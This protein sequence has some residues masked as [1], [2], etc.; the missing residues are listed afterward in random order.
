MMMVWTVGMAS[1]T[2]RGCGGACT[3][4]GGVPR[5]TPWQPVQ[6]AR[7]QDSRLQASSPAHL[8][9]RSVAGPQY[10][11][12]HAACRGGCS[13]ALPR[14][15]THFRTTWSSGSLRSWRRPSQWAARTSRCM[16]CA[17]DVYG[18][19][20]LTQ[21]QLVTLAASFPCADNR[22]SYRGRTAPDG[23]AGMAAA[24]GEGARGV[25]ASLLAESC[26]MSLYH[27]QSL[28]KDLGVE[29]HRLPAAFPTFCFTERST[30][31]YLSSKPWA[32]RHIN[33]QGLTATASH[34]ILKCP[35]GPAQGAQQAADHAAGGAARGRAAQA[36][37]GRAHPRRRASAAAAGRA[38]GGALAHRARRPIR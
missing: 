11:T 35:S 19:C 31:R 34:Q 25:R 2:G 8:S 3:G 38:W 17:K 14:A 23:R 36:P 9:T 22:G 37:A 7:R 6:L 21:G 29:C 13:A 1:V 15:W 27:L 16:F 12:Q 30:C 26:C 24:D 10:T 5:S 18:L 28:C 4:P 33:T 32:V 20:C